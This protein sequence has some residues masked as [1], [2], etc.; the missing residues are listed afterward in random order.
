LEW[1]AQYKDFTR[2]D[3][4]NIKMLGICFGQ[5]LGGLRRKVREEDGGLSV[6]LPLFMGRETLVTTPTFSTFPM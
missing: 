6:E 2:I 3:F 1:I 5:Q 4:P